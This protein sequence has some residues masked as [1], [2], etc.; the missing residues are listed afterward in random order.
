MRWLLFAVCAVER[1]NDRAKSGNKPDV[2]ANAELRHE[3][4]RISG[5]KSATARRRFVSALAAAASQWE[6]NRAWAWQIHSFLEAASAR[7][8]WHC[9][10]PVFPRRPLLLAL[11]LVSQFHPPT[12]PSLAF[13][14]SLSIQAFPPQVK[15]CSSHLFLLCV[16][17]V[18]VPSG[19]R[20]WL[21]ALTDSKPFNSIKH[22]FFLFHVFDRLFRAVKADQPFPTE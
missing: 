2:I 4:S 22:F 9:Q 14:M 1:E 20:Q 6:I 11:N 16:V 15:I 12:F 21:S 19:E 13:D 18:G 7:I 8:S 17:L 3:V 5:A 10:L